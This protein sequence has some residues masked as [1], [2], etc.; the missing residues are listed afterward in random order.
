MEKGN[1]NDVSRKALEQHLG[2]KRS[3]L[4]RAKE[5]KARLSAALDRQDI[6]IATLN[7]EIEELK[8]DLA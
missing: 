2:Y 4:K 6:D 7:R 3:E 5:D 8:A 1:M